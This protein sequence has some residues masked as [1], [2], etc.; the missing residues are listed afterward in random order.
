MLLYLLSEGASVNIEDLQGNTPLSLSIKGGHLPLVQILLQ[1]GAD[2]HHAQGGTTVVE[3][4]MSSSNKNIVYIFEQLDFITAIPDW[5]ENRAPKPRP[6][7]KYSFCRQ[8]F[9]FDPSPPPTQALVLQGREKTNKKLLDAA[10][11]G[12]SNQ[13]STNTDPSLPF[14]SL[15]FPSLPFLFFFNKNRFL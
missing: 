11:N 9:S 5:D 6:P 13:V 8:P 1:A 10:K 12:R 14:P 3:M 2:P 7:L 4:G 15:P